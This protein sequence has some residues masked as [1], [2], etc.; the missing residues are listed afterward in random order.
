MSAKQAAALDAIAQAK[1]NEEVFE[2]SLE[3]ARKRK[4][5]AMSKALKAGCTAASVA[6]AAD[7]KPSRMVAL[8]K[9]GK[10]KA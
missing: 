8:K 2:Q 5:K 6:V 3:T 10:I 4:Y 9:A 1:G 7:V